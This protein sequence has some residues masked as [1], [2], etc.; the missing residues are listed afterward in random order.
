MSSNSG[1]GKV[2]NKNSGQF[3]GKL[4]PFQVGR[5]VTVTGVRAEQAAA[6][7]DKPTAMLAGTAPAVNCDDEAVVYKLSLL[8]YII[9]KAAISVLHGTQASRLVRCVLD[10]SFVCQ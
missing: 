4:L 10:L 9:T 2:M 1:C 7:R 6:R 3:V 5:L 8:R